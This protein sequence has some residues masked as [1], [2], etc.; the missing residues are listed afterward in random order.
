[1]KSNLFLVFVLLSLIR[2]KYVLDPHD[3]ETNNATKH[4][5]ELTSIGDSPSQ[6]K[7]AILQLTY[8]SE[9]QLDIRI[10]D[11]N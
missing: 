6:F 10:Y 2:A 1:M 3:L 9:N 5:Y 4:S 11:K 8:E 7:K